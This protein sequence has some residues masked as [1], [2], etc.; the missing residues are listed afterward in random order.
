MV[1]NCNIIMFQVLSKFY[2]TA[3]YNQIKKC[4]LKNLNRLMEDR[5]KEKCIY[6]NVNI[7]HMTH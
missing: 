4:K 5:S 6:S 7:Y 2:H 1:D 3:F